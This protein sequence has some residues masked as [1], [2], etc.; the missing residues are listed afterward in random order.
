MAALVRR[1]SISSRPGLEKLAI[2]ELA[3]SES[4][5]PPAMYS[6]LAGK[7]AVAQEGLPESV[8]ALER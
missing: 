2:Q 8:L 3:Q 6:Q 1:V 4:L 5:I 7:D